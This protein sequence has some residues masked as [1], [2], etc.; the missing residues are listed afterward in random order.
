MTEERGRRAARPAMA[1]GVFLAAACAAGSAEPAARDARLEAGPAGP[2]AW[3]D[4]TLSGIGQAGKVRLL[5]FTLGERVERAVVQ[6]LGMAAVDVGGLKLDRGRLTGQVVI[7]HEP[8]RQNKSVASLPSRMPL[9][10]ELTL[11]GGQV[12][13]TFAGSWPKRK[14]L[15]TPVDVKGTVAGVR[16]DEAALRSANALDAGAAWPS[17]LG[18]NQNFSSGPCDRPLVGDLAEARMVWASRYVGPPEGGSHRY[19]ACAGTP[20]AAGGASPLVWRGRVYQFRLQPAGEAWQ[21]HLDTILAGQ[22]GD[23]TRRKMQA[24]GWTL[25]DMRRRWAIDADEQLL[26]LDAATGRCLWTVTWPGE[27]LL[28]FSHK[29]GLTNHTGTVAEIDGEGRV[30]VFGA[31]GIVRCVA[32]ETGRV[33]WAAAVPGYS[34]YMAKLKAK[35]LAA[36]HLAAPTRSFCHGLNVSGTTVVAPDGIGSCGLVGLDGRTGKVLWRVAKVLGKLATPMAFAAG[37]RHY[38]LAANGAGAIT[39][40]DAADG[41][42]AWQRTDAGANE[43]QTLLAGE[44]LLARATPAARLKEIATA[45]KS[46][47]PQ[48]IDPGAVVS[49]PG[50]NFGQVACWRLSADGARPAWTAPLEWGAPSMCPIGSAAGDLVCFR[51][52]YSY[53]IVRAATGE[54]IASSHLSAPARFD[55]GHLLALPGVFVVHPDTQHGHTKMYLYPA[56]AGAKIGPLWSPPHPH[57]TTYQ[58]PM[59]HAWAAGRLFLRG[60]DAVYCYD[61][62]EKGGRGQPRR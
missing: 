43:S 11:T 29:C 7:A 17:W 4:C 32:A 33:L 15:T 28:V 23:E 42:V 34:D 41:Q 39:C 48:E 22:R 47:K 18:P 58:C 1:A 8:R 62:R 51:G 54:R 3:I 46:K 12:R 13:G 19:G 6:P 55:E 40:I 5:I 25:A 20:P 57:A 35:A 9:R 10:L 45:M 30:F 26:C 37:G 49:A 2:A 21:K 60:A 14:S 31:M 24:V 50:S 36:R 27:G 44:M 56:A 38:V 59:S 16:R 52:N 53:Y 61:L